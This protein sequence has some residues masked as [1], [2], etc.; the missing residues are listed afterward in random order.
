MNAYTDEELAGFAAK[1]QT[2][3]YIEELIV[4]Y[5]TTIKKTARGFFLVGGDIDDLIQEG[6]IALVTA[7]H[8]YSPDKGASF[9]TF[10]TTCIRRRLIDVIR[11]NPPVDII[12]IS[13]VTVETLINNPIDEIIAG[14]LMATI[15]AEVNAV[16]KEIIHMFLDGF[17]YKEIATKLAVSEK[18]VDNTLQKIRRFIKK[19]I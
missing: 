18:K 7:A 1:G 3:K 17:T 12:D 2:D 15:D 5:K 8:D 13:D 6:T 4:R 10:A 16:E 19:S 14:D 9:K 11:K